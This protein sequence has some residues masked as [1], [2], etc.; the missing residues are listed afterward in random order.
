M[1]TA[2]VDTGAWI[3][4]ANRDDSHHGRARAFFRSIARDTQ[5][6]TSSYVVGETITWLTYRHRR[7][8]ALQIYRTIADSVRIQL[9][10]IEWITPDVQADAWQIY[11][12]YDDQLFSFCDCTSFAVCR[13]KEVDFVFGFDRDFLV[14]GFDLRPGL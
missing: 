1:T 7:E 8:Q 6:L 13:S 9:L 2:F 3:A 5:L 10:T 12:R 11:E 4:L 14:A